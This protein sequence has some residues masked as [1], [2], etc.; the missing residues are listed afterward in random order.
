LR[1]FEPAGQSVALGSQSLQLLIAQ[2]HASLLLDGLR[3][4][5]GLAR[6]DFLELRLEA[7]DALLGRHVRGEQNVE[8]EEREESAAGD[9]EPRQPCARSIGHVADSSKSA[10]IDS[11]D[12]DGAA[13]LLRSSDPRELP[14]SR[15][16]W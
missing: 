14:R 2:R 6:I 13:T 7:G 4:Q 11:D 3:L 9:D 5:R 16:R 15:A 8:E 12:D 10:I 1:F